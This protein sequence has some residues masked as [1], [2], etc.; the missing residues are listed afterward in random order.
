MVLSL[1]YVVGPR[2]VSP[3]LGPVSVWSMLSF[4]IWVTLLCLP[5]S[6]ENGLDVFHFS[7]LVEKNTATATEPTP[8]RA[9]YI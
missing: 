5:G 1:S 9:I 4:G 6:P 8:P 3:V 7:T 2:R